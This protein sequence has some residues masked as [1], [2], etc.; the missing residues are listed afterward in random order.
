MAEYYGIHYD[1]VIEHHGIKGQKWGV[2]R[3][4]NPDGT[5]T[6][7]GKKH[8]RAVTKDYDFTLKKGA[9][10]YRVSTT[11][12]DPIEDN[13]KYVSLSKEERA[14]WE[15]VL[16]RAYLRRNQLTYNVSYKTT[17]DIRVASATT[18][19]K[20]FT[21]MMLDKK[22]S[23]KSKIDTDYSKRL[24]GS[25]E[26]SDPAENASR[27]VMGRT[28]TGKMF[29]Q[30]L[31]DLGYDA[32]VDVHGYNVADAPV[33]ILNADKNLKRR[34]VLTTYTAPVANEIRKGSLK[35]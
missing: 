2:R 35:I 16:G 7:E 20:V 14:K 4:Q 22:F 9:K 10:L 18:Q 26:S 31:L 33:I 27:N 19:G 23:E 25:L 3:Y 1:S 5:L 12:K 8:I 34:K 13:K 15:E 24:L 32:I 30:K 11:G 17:K 21:D 28:E 29:T 6:E